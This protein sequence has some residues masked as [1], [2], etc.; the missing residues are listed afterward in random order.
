MRRLSEVRTGVYAVPH[1][2]IGV[3]AAATAAAAP[4]AVQLCIFMSN[5]EN[6]ELILHFRHAADFQE[7]EAYSAFIPEFLN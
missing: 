2:S 4:A 3:S 6:Y 7:P 1:Q 5:C